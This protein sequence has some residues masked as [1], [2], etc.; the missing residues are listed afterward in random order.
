MIHQL[1]VPIVAGAIAFNPTLPEVHQT[2][3]AGLTANH[4]TQAETACLLG[5]PFNQAHWIDHRVW[6][7]DTESNLTYGPFLVVDVA[8]WRHAGVMQSNGL[9]ADTNCRW[10]VHARGYIYTLETR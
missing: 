10:L 4:V 8:Q 2:R 5:L 7:R 3:A 9:A 6:F 1:L